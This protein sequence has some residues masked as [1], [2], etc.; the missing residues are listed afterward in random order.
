M[1]NM[2]IVSINQCP[3]NRCIGCVDWTKNKDTDSHYCV[4]RESPYYLRT[5]TAGCPCKDTEGAG[6]HMG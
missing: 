2:I 3:E 5:T 1:N 6:E 4:C